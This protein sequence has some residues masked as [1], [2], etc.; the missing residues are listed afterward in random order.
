MPGEVLEVYSVPG[1]VTWHTR[2]WFLGWQRLNSIHIFQPPCDQGT[3]AH[4]VVSVGSSRL[5]TLGVV[6]K[7]L[8]IVQKFCLSKSLDYNSL[9]KSCE[10]N[11]YLGSY[12][13]YQSCTVKNGPHP[14]FKFG[15]TEL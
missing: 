14:M 13:V 4:D 5:L 15:S 11:G 9:S 2:L 6:C 10:N 8:D 1:L 7:N 3:M 12:Y